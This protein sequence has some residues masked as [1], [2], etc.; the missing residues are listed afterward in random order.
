MI[1][2]EFEE[3]SYPAGDFGMTQEAYN[4]PSRRLRLTYPCSPLVR[5]SRSRLFRIN[6][7]KEQPQNADHAY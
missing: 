3:V 1:T 4:C 7:K 2:E 5:P 6:P